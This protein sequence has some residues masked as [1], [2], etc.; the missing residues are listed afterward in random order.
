MDNSV[1]GIKSEDFVRFRFAE[2]PNMSK[3]GKLVF[4]I[5][6]VNEKKNSYR[7]GLY[8][9]NKESNDYFRYTSGTH[10][11][12]SAKF[13]PSGKFLAFLS[14]RAE[15]GMQVF[16]MSVTGGEALQVTNFPKGVL[17]YTWSHDSRSLHVLARV[18]L[19]ELESI[20]KPRKKSS[21]VLNPVDFEVEQ[22]KESTLTSLSND[23]RVIKDGYY[24]E[25]T[26]FL[27]GRKAQPFVVPV[28]NFNHD[29]KSAP[30][31]EIL[32]IGNIEYHYTLG[33]FNHD[34]TQIILSKYK[35]DPSVTFLHEVLSIKI[36]DPTETK[37]YGSAFGWVS[38]FTL[39]PNGNK[40]LYEAKREEKSVF[41]DQ[42]I[43][44]CNLGNSEDNPID[45][46]TEKFHRSA[47]LACWLNDELVIFLSPIDGRNSLQKI[48]INTKLVEELIGGDRN[49]NSFS[50]ARSTRDLAFEVSHNSFP[51]D[52]F[53]TNLN[54]PVETRITK[55]NSDYLL[56]HP[57]AKL[58]SFTFQQNGTTLQG[59]ILYPPNTTVGDKIPVVVEIHG[60]PAAMWSPHEKT[61]WHEW[62]C[63]VGRGFGVVFCNPRGSDGYG[64]EFRKA[65]FENWGTIAQNDILKGLD[66]ALKMYP[67]LNSEQVSVTGGSYGG[68]MTAWLITQTN[69]FKAAVSQRGVYEFSGF[70]LTT[71]IPI[72]FEHH[73]GEI[74]KE[75]SRNWSDAPVAHVKN[76]STPL[77][78]IH[79]ENDYRVPI[80]SAEQLFW[81]G[82]KYDK[83][84]EFIRYPRDGH[85]LSRS[86]EPR[87]IVD[88]IKRIIQ[89]IEKYS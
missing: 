14:S 18:N 86:G 55:V 61:M 69:R 76:I 7:G 43:F 60:G 58:E 16:I 87:H 3:D 68:Y 6:S 33:T 51:S 12:T 1:N 17:G 41:D 56:K 30:L 82:K 35:D 2:N 27:E 53:L 25:G 44:I 34:N 38:N 74:L 73:Y 62:N 84:M 29:R 21:F 72:W 83:V 57:C 28:D 64:I 5:R 39:S 63:L 47:S 75:Y 77:L 26:H 10:L 71:D 9:K 70:G 42:Q 20:L 13:A 54:N 46:L 65:V 49:I 22:I 80:V 37:L 36:K 79:A 67:F 59:W 8:L 11:D 52:I 40:F 32:H 4:T 81:L 66:T 31:S 89:W 78:I 15:K 19:V 45:C 50:L 23:P 85:E 24:R 48:D 88:R